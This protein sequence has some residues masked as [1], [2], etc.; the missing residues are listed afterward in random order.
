MTSCRA[1]FCNVGMIISTTTANPHILSKRIMGSPS[2]LVIL[3]ARLLVHLKE[4]GEKGFNGGTSY[5]VRKALS[6][7]EFGENAAR[8]GGGS[9]PEGA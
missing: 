2:L 4:A 7:I 5:R 8:E 3:G 6:A 9:A 1:I